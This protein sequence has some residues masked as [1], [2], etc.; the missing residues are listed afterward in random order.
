MAFVVYKVIQDHMKLSDHVD[1]KRC[2]QLVI[3]VAGIYIFYLATGVI[4]E[5]MYRTLYPG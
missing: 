2:L 4:H 3:G 5:S 1:P